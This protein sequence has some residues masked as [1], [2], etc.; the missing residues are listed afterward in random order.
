MRA[1]ALRAAARAGVE[2]DDPSWLLI[3][4]A[5]ASPARIAIV[6]AQDLLS[7]GS[8]A[9]MNT[10]GSKRGNWQWRLEPGQ[11]DDALAARLRAAT[12]AAGRHP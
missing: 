1:R 3:G 8:E 6:P 2:T 5:L 4:L 11:L 9:R 10:P 12:L 7:L